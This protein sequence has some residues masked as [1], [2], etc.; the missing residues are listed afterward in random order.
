MSED[1]KKTCQIDLIYSTADASTP[2]MTALRDELA[3]RGYPVNLKSFS[4]Q[5]NIVQEISQSARDF[6]QT[7]KEVAESATQKLRDVLPPIGSLQDKD[8][9]AEAAKKDSNPFTE[10]GSQVKQNE[11]RAVIVTDIAALLNSPW[12][13]YRIGLIPHTEL[14]KTW[15]PNQLDAIVTPHKAFRGYL[16]SVRW[17]AERIFEGGWL[18]TTKA[19]DTPEAIRKRFGLTTEAGPILL[20]LAS[21]CNAQDIQTIMLQLSL[22]RVPYQAFFYYGTNSNNASELQNQACRFGIN[23]RMFGK[24]RDLREL[25]DCFALADLAIAP[26]ADPDFSMLASLA[27]PTLV[28][29]ENASSALTQFLVHEGAASLVKHTYELASFLAAPVSQKDV[30]ENMQKAAKSIADAASVVKCADAIE[31]ALASKEQLKNS[32]QPNRAAE[33]IFQT[34][35]SMPQPA[36]SESFLA[37]TTTQPET[38]FQTITP[39]AQPIQQPAVMPVQPVIQPQAVYTA[40]VQPT[41]AP[42]IAP[43]PRAY[44]DIHREYTQL[45]LTEKE[46]DRSLDAAS[47]EVS[48]WEERLDLARQNNNDKLFNEAMLRLK[49]AQATEMQLFQ[50]KDQLTQQKNLLRQSAQQYKGASSSIFSTPTFIDDEFSKPEDDQLEKEFN[51]LQRRQRLIDLRHKMGLN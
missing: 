44:Q 27:V 31:A 20:I 39:V 41:L 42:A 30:L 40:P 28:V 51:N 18:S 16:E 24:P 11:D 37:P 6:A 4:P 17:G 34:I 8:K 33:T 25:A 5:T 46:L 2:E 35:G 43:N 19:T 13:I 23:A 12:D 21:S 38:P 49:T 14:N 15:M 3:K 1:K 29:S 7:V 50:Q 26:Q 47:S 22:I 10:I 32:N 9:K 48:K 36:A 45:L